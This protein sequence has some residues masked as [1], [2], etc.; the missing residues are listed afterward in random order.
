MKIILYL[1]FLVHCTFCS[2]KKYHNH[3]LYR[4]IPVTEKHL[5]F[6]KNL[7]DNYNANYWRPPGL[8]YRPVEFVIP[9]EKKRQ[10]T[11]DSLNQGVYLTTIIEDIQR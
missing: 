2:S 7:S 1:I 6:F 10:F 3:T 11:R 4:G 8:I 9:P 5:D